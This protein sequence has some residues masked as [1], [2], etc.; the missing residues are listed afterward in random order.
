MLSLKTDKIG[1]VYVS[2]ELYIAD[3]PCNKNSVAVGI[4][5]RT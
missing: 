2:S 3:T 1:R 4:N 5:L